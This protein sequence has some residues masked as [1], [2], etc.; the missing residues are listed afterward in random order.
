MFQNQTYASMR[1]NSN[2]KVFTFASRLTAPTFTSLRF[3]RVIILR[4]PPIATR[5]ARACGR[6]RRP[7]RPA[8]P[9]A[10][11]CA[12]RTEGGAG[13]SR[14]G[15]SVGAR[16]SHAARRGR[17]GYFARRAV[18]GCAGGSQFIA[19]GEGADATSASLP[20]RHSNTSRVLRKLHRS[21][22]DLIQN[23]KWQPKNKSRQKTR[24]RTGSAYKKT[25]RHKKA[26]S[27]ST[28]RTAPIFGWAGSA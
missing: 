27:K 25:Y 8:S 26:H 23:R 18:S 28:M 24:H 17:R 4:F 5:L 7:R 12:R 19:A 21:M 22:A 20:S 6:G 14:A 3:H 16:E 10:F 1:Y 13:T 15:P 2:A 11:P 9:R